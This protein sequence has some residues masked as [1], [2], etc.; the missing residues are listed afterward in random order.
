M[1]SARQDAARFEDK[2]IKLD[3][4]FQ[5]QRRQR[6][7]TTIFVVSKQTLFVVVT[8]NIDRVAAGRYIDQI[9]QR[10]SKRLRDAERDAQRWVGR[11]AFD[12]AEHRSTHTA[13]RRQLL[14]SPTFFLTQQTHLFADVLIQWF[15]S[16]R[17]DRFVCTFFF[18]SC[19]FRG[20]SAIMEIASCKEDFRCV[21]FCTILPVYK[22]SN[23]G[24]NLC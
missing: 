8:H 12:L 14:K 4:L 10:H 18:F 19:P 7:N 6:S 17:L 16:R 23:R 20:I 13:E 1:R 9:A 2:F 21:S 15:E 11:A 5:M 3:V 22:K 24:A